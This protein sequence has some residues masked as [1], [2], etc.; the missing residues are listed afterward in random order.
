MY[1]TRR[2]IKMVREKKAIDVFICCFS[3]YKKIPQVSKKSGRAKKQ[4]H[5]DQGRIFPLDEIKGK[6]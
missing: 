2:P 5:F 4:S 1:I 3:A 6:K